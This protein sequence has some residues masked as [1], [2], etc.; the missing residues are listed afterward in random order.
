MLPLQNIYCM[1]GTQTTCTCT[2]IL[3]TID[4][5][6]SSSLYHHT[7]HSGLTCVETSMRCPQWRELKLTDIGEL[8]PI[9]IEPLVSHRITSSIKRT[10]QGVGLTS[11]RDTGSRGGDH[12]ND[13]KRGKR[14]D[15]TFGELF[16]LSMTILIVF[17]FTQ[18][19]QTIGPTCM[20]TCIPISTQTV[21]ST[22]VSA[23]TT[24]QNSPFGIVTSVLTLFRLTVPSSPLFL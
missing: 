24:Q 14:M 2:E 17:H 15:L 22:P 21:C 16:A 11:S 19:L 18:V 1:H 6:S 3:L 12:N 8:S 20:M 13:C 7:P 10:V 4:I 9:A 5:H 23:G